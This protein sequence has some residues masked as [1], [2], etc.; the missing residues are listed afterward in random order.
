M[1]LLPTTTATIIL[2][3]TTTIIIIIISTTCMTPPHN[4]EL[5]PPSLCQHP[6]FQPFPNQT[7]ETSCIIPISGMMT[8]L[9]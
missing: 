5:P 4:T 3:S 2:T 7:Q 6:L 9:G 8:V 1:H